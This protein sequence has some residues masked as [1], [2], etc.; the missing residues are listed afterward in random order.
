MPLSSDSDGLSHAMQVITTG[1]IKTHLLWVYLGM[2]KVQV[3]IDARALDTQI[4]ERARERE[5]YAA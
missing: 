2:H 5:R 1:F 3:R 4:G